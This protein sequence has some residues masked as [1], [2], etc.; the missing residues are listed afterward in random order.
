MNVSSVAQPP[1]AS[2]AYAAA[3]DCADVGTSIVM[4][5]RTLCRA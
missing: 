2:V 5:T 3:C 1:A 4:P